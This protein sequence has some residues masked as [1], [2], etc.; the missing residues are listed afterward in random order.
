MPEEAILTLL[1]K[2]AYEGAIRAI[3]RIN[4][5]EILKISRITLKELLEILGGNEALIY[6]SEP[7]EII[8]YVEKLN[9]KKINKDEIDFVYTEYASRL[10]RVFSPLRSYIDNIESQDEILLEKDFL[11]ALI[12]LGRIAYLVSGNQRIKDMTMIAHAIYLLNKSKKPKKEKIKKIIYIIY[13]LI[14]ITTLWKLNRDSPHDRRVPLTL[15]GWALR[16]EINIKPYITINNNENKTKNID[17]WADAYELDY[18]HKVMNL[19]DGRLLAA[20]DFNK[21]L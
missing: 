3:D 15:L 6:T 18:L 9:I 21:Y 2:K 17:V 1:D 10:Q 19:V 5:N 4:I 12:V 16:D 13:S 14:Q 20:W 11:V 7:A 8:D